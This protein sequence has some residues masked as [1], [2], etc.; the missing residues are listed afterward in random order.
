MKTAGRDRG[1][2]TGDGRTSST[3]ARAGARH[4]ARRAQTRKDEN[5]PVHVHVGASIIHERGEGVVPL[6]RF[7]R[8]PLAPEAS[9]LS[10]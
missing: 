2:T 8:R 5:L 9:A 10:S 6:R 3:D 7:E 4:R 1:P